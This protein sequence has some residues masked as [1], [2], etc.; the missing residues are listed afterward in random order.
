MI[1]LECE[2]DKVL[3]SAMG[4]PRKEIKHSFSKGNV[5]NRLE[6]SRNSKGLVDEDPLSMQPSYIKEL[7]LYEEKDEIKLLY[8]EKTQNYLI[9][10]CPTL[11]EWIL[12]VVKEA[13]IDI[14]SYGLPDDR[15]KLHETINTKLKN[16]KNLIDD[17]KQKSSMLKTLEGFVKR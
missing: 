6:K 7:K 9:V 5:C 2:P 13:K 8:D 17:I 16:L 11:E 1:Y 10:L 4:I 14:S 3:V 15:G 12:K